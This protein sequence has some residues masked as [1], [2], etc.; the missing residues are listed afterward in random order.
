[1]QHSYSLIYLNIFSLYLYIRTIKV[2]SNIKH[3]LKKIKTFSQK[4]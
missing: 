2:V 3:N 4:Y 1:M